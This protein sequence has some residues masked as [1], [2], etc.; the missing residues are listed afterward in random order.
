MVGI[1]ISAVVVPLFVL[2]MIIILI[3]ITVAMKKHIR[4]GEVNTTANHTV[5]SVDN[6]T[7]TAEPIPDKSFP[8]DYEEPLKS[9]NN[10]LEPSTYEVPVDVESQDVVLKSVVNCIYEEE[11][12]SQPLYEILPSTPNHYYITNNKQ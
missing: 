4:K 9:Y 12:T 1:T 2:L 6:I 8:K 3:V 7:Y 5:E 11:E 10:T